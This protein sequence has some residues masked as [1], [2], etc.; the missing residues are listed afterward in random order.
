M[1]NGRT[2]LSV[3]I[4]TVNPIGASL[5]VGDLVCPLRLV[6]GRDRRVL[7]AAAPHAVRLP[8]MRRMTIRC[9][10]LPPD[11]HLPRVRST[12]CQLQS[13]VG[14]ELSIKP[15]ALGHALPGPRELRHDGVEL[16][17]RCAPGARDMR[18]RKRVAAVAAQQSAALPELG[19]P[20]CGQVVRQRR[21]RQRAAMYRVDPLE[22]EPRDPIHHLPNRILV[23]ENARRL[24]AS[25]IA[26]PRCSVT[27][28]S[29]SPGCRKRSAGGRLQV[30]TTQC[31]RPRQS[32][33]RCGR[34]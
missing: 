14:R 25:H 7:A 8:L 2:L 4:T 34:S 12:L 3:V 32:G 29:C 13:R 18:H 30:P 27:I 23:R 17:G 16:V 15:P 21:A 26:S 20:G 31:G 11:V 33:G 9:P 19:A 24:Y 28:G 22:I 6:S 5:G 1:I 10:L